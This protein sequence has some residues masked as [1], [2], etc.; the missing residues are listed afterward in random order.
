MGLLEQ[1]MAKQQ[2]KA[3]VPDEP[4]PMPKKGR[5]TPNPQFEDTDM[6]LGWIVENKPPPKTVMKYIKTRLNEIF[7]EEINETN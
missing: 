7:T 4:N 6:N 2:A 5:K 3:L 1:F